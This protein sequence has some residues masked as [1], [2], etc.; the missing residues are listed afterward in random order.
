MVD[1]SQILEFDH[2]SSTREIW[3]DLVFDRCIKLQTCEPE[4]I[5]YWIKMPRIINEPEKEYH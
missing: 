3:F 2:L 1:K 4:Q 5:P